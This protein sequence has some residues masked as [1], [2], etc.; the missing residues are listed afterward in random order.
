MS[1]Y[2]DDPEFEQAGAVFTQG[3]VLDGALPGPVLAA[4]V[5]S[6]AA[7]DLSGLGDNELLGL[8]S[9]ARRVG[10]WAAWAQTMAEARYAAR[11]TELDTR[12]GK[13]VIGEFAPQDLAQ[14][15]H[16]TD[17]AARDR[18]ERA[19]AAAGRL[20]ECLELL[21][22]GRIDEF[23]L[24]II[25]ETTAS[26][27][28]VIA[29]KADE[30]IAA[31]AA[32]RTHGSLRRLCK[33]IV[34][35]LDPQATEENRKNAATSRRAEVMQEYSGNGMVCL[36]EISPLDALGIKANLDR[37]ARIM[38]D[39]GIAGSLDNLRADAATALLIQRHPVTGTTQPAGTG[40]SGT[41]ATGSGDGDGGPWAGLQ[42]ADQHP[43]D[44]AEDPW[45]A[46]YSPWE[47]TD[48]GDAEGT[49][50]APLPLNTDTT[51]PAAVINLLIPAG[52]LDGTSGAPAQIA[53]FGYLGGD[54]ARD[55]AAAASRNPA[56][57]W[58]V[59]ATGTD[60]TAASHACIP[61]QHRWDPP[62]TGPP[63]TGSPGNLITGFIMNL[64]PRFTTIA[65]HPGD[66]GHP[67][68]RHDPSRRLTHLI[69]ARNATCA[70]P[71][72]GAA[73]VT[74]DMEHTIAWEDGGPTDEYNLDPRC[75][76]HHRLKQRSDWKVSKPGPA[77]TRWTGPSGR[78]RTI[79]ATRYLT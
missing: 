37:W 71:G 65:R 7:G 29:G 5:G 10:A 78:T 50:A 35:L 56:T 11:N 32:G 34:M 46:D 64:K 47:Y 61:G 2:W 53:G 14:E 67:E 36:R 15:I 4:A 16:L 17:T 52:L 57:R 18:L 49:P 12:T 19:A 79:Q 74:A 42:P 76:H 66:D 69:Q 43:G 33:K 73:A 20:P 38:R 72:C 51:G 31:Q 8:V 13:E 6:I 30:M 3:A 21:R 54:A 26:L 75:R 63:G 39:A 28:D 23:G 1:N 60:G 24:K 77:T 9:A 68:P 27:A 41:G 25:T 45:A 44:I 40:A 59:T 58:C 48:H 55:L 62:A 70:T 22:E